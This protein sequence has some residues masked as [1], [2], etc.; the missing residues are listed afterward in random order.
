MSNGAA[1]QGRAFHL[2]RRD[3]GCGIPGFPKEGANMGTQHL[4]AKAG[5]ERKS[6]YRSAE[7]LRHQR[8]IGS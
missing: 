5:L 6:R 8:H 1:F 3:W 2:R 4:S 7:V